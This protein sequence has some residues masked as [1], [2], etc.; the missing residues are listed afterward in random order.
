MHVS[1]GNSGSELNSGQPTAK[2]RASTRHSTPRDQHAEDQNSLLLR[3]RDTGKR[4]RMFVSEVRA[5]D[6]KMQPVQ[7]VGGVALDV[8]CVKR[9]GR[10]EQ[11]RRLLRSSLALTGSAPSPQSSCGRSLLVRRV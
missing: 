10:C 7:P 3:Q 6:V 5:I 9:P 2:R 4:R 11:R 1:G 8:V